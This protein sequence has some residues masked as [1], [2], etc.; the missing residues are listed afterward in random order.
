MKAIILNYPCLSVDAVEIPAD[1]IKDCDPNDPTY[2]V[3]TYLEE[4]DY[5]IDS[6]NYMIVDDDCP[7]YRKTDAFNNGELMATL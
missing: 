2:G 1:A 6:I 7:V 3:E 5:S 4:L